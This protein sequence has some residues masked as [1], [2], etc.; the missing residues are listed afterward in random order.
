MILSVTTGFVP[1][2]RSIGFFNHD[3]TDYSYNVTPDGLPE[4]FFMAPSIINVT[5][6]GTAFCAGQPVTVNYAVSD[7]GG[8]FNILNTFTA[9]LSSDTGTFISPVNIGTIVSVNSGS[10]N[11]IIPAGTVFGTRYR[12]R[13]VSSSPLI[14]SAPDTSDL[15]INLIPAVPTAVTATPSSVCSGAVSNL[16][17]ISAGDSIRWYTARTGGSLLG[18]RVSGALFPVTSAVTTTYYAEAYRAGRCSSAS[19]VGVT[20]TINAGPSA[21]GV[22]TITQPTCLQPTGSVVINNLPSNSTWILTRYPGGVTMSGSGR[23]TTITGLAP[24]TY[25]FTVSR[26][27]GCPSAPSSNVVINPPPST[28]PAPQISN[29]TQPTCSVLTGSIVLNSLPAGQ[30]VLTR[31]PGNVT[32]SGTGT[33]TTVSGLSAG[34]YTFTVTTG[35]GCPSPPSAGAVISAPPPIPGVPVI[36]IDCSLGFGHA[37]VTVTSPVGAGLRYSLDAGAYQASPLFINVANGNHQ[38]SVVNPEG[39]T[40]AGLVFEVNCPCINQP[41][42]QL[43][44]TS[45]STCGRTPVTVSGNRFGGTATSVTITEDGAGSVTPSTALSSPFSFTYTPVSADRGRTVRIT[46]TTNNP[47]GFPCAQATQTYELMVVANPAVP[48]IGNI[49][50]PNC[51]SETGSVELNGLPSGAWTLTIYPDDFSVTGSGTSSTVSDLPEGTYTFTV[52]NAYG[53]TSGES[54]D[55]VVNSPPS[56]PSA[57][58]TG[59]TTQ[60]SCGISTGSVVLSN[61][62]SSGTWTLNRSPDGV[63]RTGTGTTFTVPN[64]PAGTYTFTVTN[65][66]G[67]TSVPSHSFVINDQPPTPDPPDMGSVT[68]PTCALGTGSINILGL[69]SHGTWTLTRYPGTIATEGSGTS[70]TVAGISPGTYVFT[71]RN[72]YGCVSVPSENFVMPEQPPPPPVPVVASVVQPTFLVPTGSV[73]LTGL[74]ST[75][76]WRITRLPDGTVTEGSGRQ[77]IMVYLTSGVYTFT[78]TNSIGCTSAQTPEVNIINPGKPVII[79][80]NPPE[81]CYPATADLTAPAITAGS[82]QDLRFTYWSDPDATIEY[83]IPAAAVAGTYYIKGTNSSGFFDIKPVIVRIYQLPAANAGPDQLLFNQFNTTMEAVLAENETGI[84]SVET[85]EG[86]IADVTDPF[87]AVIDLA[88]GNN[89]LMWVVDNGLC[90]ADTDKVMLIVGDI[91][92]PTLITPNGDTKNEYFVIRGLESL[93]ESELIIFDRKGTEL[94]RNSDY[95]NKWNGVDQNDNPLPNDTYFYLLSTAKGRSYRGYIMIR[96]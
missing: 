15:T 67:C 14:V 76:R 42:V 94:F 91:N 55:A 49:I 61:L 90:P 29:I 27:T 34:T 54:D 95:D 21:P 71:V 35:G 85:G 22:G 75:G 43:S 33:S 74:P 2:R 31:S 44:S 93:G 69:P 28:L 78:V 41:T 92:V 50:Q 66:E 26:T 52:T 96:R 4:S 19:R 8:F 10:I 5:V 36:S 9:Q 38:I 12:I 70:T 87:T 56:P 58:Q 13:V 1:D 81:A 47:L 64:I 59:A 84:W 7:T 60:P 16:S 45:G 89:T 53:C 11:A 48:V 17:A 86:T 3:L 24:G 83:T 20:V 40:S 65:Q 82:E 6:N 79:I 46:V 72:H 62:P 25:Y 39:C 77:Y 18:T 63:T 23:R 51:T 73:E 57:P 30:W 68:Q 88:A 80:T 32:T 37:S